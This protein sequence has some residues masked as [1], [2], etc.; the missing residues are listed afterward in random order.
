[1][2]NFAFIRQVGPLKWALRYSALLATRKILRRDLGMR[3]PTGGRIILP[4][5]S[6]S[7]AEVWV[8]GADIDWGSEAI[9][10]RFADRNRDF[11][12]VGSHIG[13][14]AAYLAPLVRRVVAFEPDSRNHAALRRNADLAGNV[15]VVPWAVSSLSGEVTL[16][17]G[18]GPAVGSLEASV[19][20]STTIVRSTSID[21]LVR[22]RPELDVGL[23]KT[24][25]EGHDLAALQGMAECVAR[26][27]PLV[28]TE[29][30]YSPELVRLTR[31]WGYTIHARVRDRTTFAIRLEELDDFGL[32]TCWYKMLF[33]VPPRLQVRFQ[34][35]RIATTGS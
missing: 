9:F 27:A 29:C 15:E 30:A 20:G 5:Y 21:E 6:P 18:T 26:F 11:L 22:S 14:Y 25:I 32:R 31:A 33:L 4:R 28:I 12:D 17:S 13:Y 8:T 16:Y 10:A 7:A 1:M 3:L 2:P 23:V 19:G 35:T 34:D 24:D